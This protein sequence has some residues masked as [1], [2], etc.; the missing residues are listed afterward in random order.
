MEKFNN[1]YIENDKF[2][3]PLLLAASFQGFIKFL[4]SS[5]KDGILYWQFSPKNEAEKLINQF[6]TKTEP[7]YPQK[8]SI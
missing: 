4:G 7:A 2:H 1:L 8:R 5:S 6:Q 3:A